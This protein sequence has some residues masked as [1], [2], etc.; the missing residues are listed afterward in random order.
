MSHAF[1]QVSPDLSHLMV[2][3][4][5]RTHYLGDPAEKGCC[6]GALFWLFIQISHR[7]VVVS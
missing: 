1:Y 7:K 5:A 2:D 3:G 6:F 4:C